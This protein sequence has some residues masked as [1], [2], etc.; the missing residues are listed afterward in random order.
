MSTAAYLLLATVVASEPGSSPYRVNPWVDGTT[1]FAMLGLL[2]ISEG[3]VKPTLTGG[4]ACR[5]LGPTGACDPSELNSLDRTVVGNRS[6]AWGVVSDVAVI[7][8]AVVATAGIVVDTM[9]A[10]HPSPWSEIGTDLLVIAETGAAASLM[11]HMLKYAV[12]R[13]R[14]TAY[15]EPPFDGNL[16]EQLSFPSGHTTAVAS[17]SAAY[18]T[19]FA[20]RHPGSPWRFAVAGGAALITGV[21]AAGRVGDGMHFYTDVAAGALLG[22]AFGVLVPHLHRSDSWVTVSLPSEIEAAAGLGGYQLVVGFAI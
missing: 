13:P 21:T 9:A 8:S 3:L 20:L 18:A 1:T 15:G 4:L 22:A 17:M 2:G 19:T 12:R 6:G 5:A 11:A 16:E 7:S 10:G 14:P